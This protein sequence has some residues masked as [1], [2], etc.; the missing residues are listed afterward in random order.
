MSR[1]LMMMAAAFAVAF[2][3]WADTET[4]GGYMWTC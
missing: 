1:K 2:G 3:A 4:V